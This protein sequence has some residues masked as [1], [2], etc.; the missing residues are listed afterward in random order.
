MNDCLHILD[1]MYFASIA[2]FAVGFYAPGFI[3]LISTEG[4][5]FF[6]QS[7]KLDPSVFCMI[8]GTQT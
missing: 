1:L 2:E 7:Q 6:W 4:Q 3:E 8:Q 5:S